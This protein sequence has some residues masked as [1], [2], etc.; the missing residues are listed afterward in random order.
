MKLVKVLHCN[1][2]FDTLG[3]EL[4]WLSFNITAFLKVLLKSLN[5]TYQAVVNKS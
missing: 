2:A 1:K 4:F 5:A 3:H